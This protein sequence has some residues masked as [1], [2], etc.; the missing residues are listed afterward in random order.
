MTHADAVATKAVERYLLGELSAEERDGFE[1]HAFDCLECAADLKAAAT[2]LDVSRGLLHEAEAAR[3]V[4]HAPS[5]V[6]APPTRR[7]WL[8][9]LNPASLI[10]SAVLL[11][12]TLALLAFTVYQNVVTLPALKNSSTPRALSAFSFVSSGTRGATPMVIAAP[13]GQPFLLFFDIPPSER[14]VSYRCAIETASGATR[15]A[16]EVSAVQ[17]RDTVQLYVPAGRLQPGSHVLVI[18]GVAA[19]GSR[20]DTGTTTEAQITQ[21]AEIAR[22]PFVLPDGH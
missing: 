14:F 11:P 20:A 6:G 18:S 7:G 21:S 12:A 2:F 15:V 10:P 9:W 17:A 13:A 16:V 22:Y 1:E 3:A 19:G 8:A 5:A 4:N